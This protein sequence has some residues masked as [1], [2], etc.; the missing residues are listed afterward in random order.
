VD[1]YPPVEVDCTRNRRWMFTLDCDGT[2]DTATVIDWLSFY[3]NVWTDGTYKYSVGE[4][5]NVYSNTAYVTPVIRWSELV[6]S[7]N[8]IYS[9]QQDKIDQF[10]EKGSAAGVNH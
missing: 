6:G 3:W 7:V 8:N 4:L 10:T 5:T 1:Q 9:N 2:P